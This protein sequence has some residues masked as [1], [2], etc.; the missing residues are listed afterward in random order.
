[1]N[2][3]LH[4]RQESVSIRLYTGIIR[5]Q[6]SNHQL[7]RIYQALYK[8]NTPEL[9]SFRD[10]AVHRIRFRERFRQELLQL[11]DKLSR[12]NHS[13]SLRETYA[14]VVPAIYRFGDVLEETFNAFTPDMCYESELNNLNQYYKTISIPE[15]DWQT[16][17]LLEK[18]QQKIEKYLMEQM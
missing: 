8:D 1:M 9:E 16:R 18:H 4:H 2:R 14:T 13:I 12:S 15:A 10:I 11:K 5:L 17:K 7:L 3:D 6:H